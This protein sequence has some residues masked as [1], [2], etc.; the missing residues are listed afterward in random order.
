MDDSELEEYDD[1]DTV[2]TDSSGNSI[3]SLYM[4]DDF[5]GY[6]YRR[7]DQLYNIHSAGYR[8]SWFGDSLLAFYKLRPEES[9]GMRWEIVKGDTISF[10]YDSWNDSTFDRGVHYQNGRLV[11]IG[12]VDMNL[13]S[14]EVNQLKENIYR[15][16][17]GKL[18]VYKSYHDL[19]QD[20]DRL[21]TQSGVY[22]YS[23][24]GGKVDH[25][26]DLR[27]IE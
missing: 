4:G 13:D 20:F 22:Y 11:R 10:Y 3:I 6:A 2:W 19:E 24:P 12:E 16:E 1:Y 23:F 17:E 21:D 14:I 5:W 26:I 15:L 18:K 9:L 8:V 7:S 25:W 27:K